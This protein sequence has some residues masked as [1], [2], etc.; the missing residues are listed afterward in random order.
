MD[1]VSSK[2]LVSKSDFLRLSNG[3]P[4]QMPFGRMAMLSSC[5]SGF[6][7]RISVFFAT[8]LWLAAQTYNTE[9]EEAGKGGE[10]GY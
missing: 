9:L 3:T 6:R 7:T 2:I 8:P 1:L 5:C 4:G 10:S